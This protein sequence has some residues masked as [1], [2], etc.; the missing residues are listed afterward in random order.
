MD[1]E[2][3]LQGLRLG[4]NGRVPDVAQSFAMVDTLVGGEGCS[5]QGET[6]SR[7]GTLLPVEQGQENDEFFLT[8]SAWAATPMCTPTRSPCR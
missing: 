3:A 6:L 7:L 4:V 8:L 1:T 5:E 2:V